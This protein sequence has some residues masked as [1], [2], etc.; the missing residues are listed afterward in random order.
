MDAMTDPL[1]HRKGRIT[2]RG[3]PG[4]RI[5]VV[6]QRHAF[7]F[8]VAV[9][10]RLFRADPGKGFT[11]AQAEGYRDLLARR[12]NAVVHE[13]A[14]KWYVL[15]RH[16]PQADFSDA[17]AVL[18]WCEARRIAVRGHCLV[19]EKR[20]FVQDWVK[21]LS[22]QELRR[23]VEA[24]IREVVRRYRGRIDEFDVN[25][26]MLEGRYYQDRLG[27]GFCADMFRW[28][29]DEN[30]RAR[31][32]LND[33]HTLNGVLLP[34]YLAQ[35]ADFRARGAPLSGIGCQEHY[36]TE[37]KD[38]PPDPNADPDQVIPFTRPDAALAKRCLDR[39]AACGLPIVITEYDSNPDDPEAVAEDLRVLLQTAFA[40]PAVAGFYQ[41][42]FWRRSHWQ[43]CAALYGDDFAPLPAGRA[44]EDLVFNAWWTRTEATIGADGTATVEAFLGEH[45]VTVDGRTQRVALDAATPQVIAS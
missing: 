8:G 45:D 7:P 16:G 19:W 35:I 32:F 6:Q 23:A 21:A 42:G 25:N 15:N 31:L 17:D 39:L 24:H 43:P 38:A 40:H 28:A 33:Y 14:L 9:N 37:K 41:W 26:E 30:P 5:R 12:F 11:A 18:D 22:D 1:A 13:N 34:A 44:Y 27:V 29:Q 36:F 10:A 3:R 2:V 4:G 20:Q